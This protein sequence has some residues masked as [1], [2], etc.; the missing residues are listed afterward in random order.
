MLT[1][2]CPH[3]AKVFRIRPEQLSLR[4]GRVRCGNC[5]QAFSALAHLGEM[6][7]E[8]LPGTHAPEP[9]TAVKP[10]DKPVTAPV[11]ESVNAASQPAP[12]QIPS[13]PPVAPVQPVPVPPAA[14][15][16]P[17]RVVSAP[18]PAPAP[19]APQISPEFLQSAPIPLHESSPLAKFGEVAFPALDL[20][21]SG[22]PGIEAPAFVALDGGRVEEP[23]LGD[24]FTMH[25]SM[26]DEDTEVPVT[27][28]K[29]AEPEPYRS[30]IAEE[31][32]V[33]PY[34]P[35]RELDMRQT[36][37]L[38][39]PLDVIELRP[40]D[41]GPDSL[42][43]EQARQ[44]A[45]RHAGVEDRRKRARRAG[46]AGWA[47]GLFLLLLLILL[48]G[49]YL[50]R[51]EIPRA[52]PDWRPALERACALINCNVPYPRNA[53]LVSLEG[54][55]FNPEDGAEGNY[56]LIMT[57]F[58]RASYPQEWPHVELT[59]TDRFDIAISRRVLK[60]GEWLPTAYRHLPAFES[61]TEVTASL[62]LNIGELPAAG[63]RL[64]V[65]Y[66]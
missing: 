32:G 58:N 33:A 35:S 17:E 18:R 13:V 38:E 24:E 41:R 39:E 50:F 31:L 65:F 30:K 66:P 5:Q 42:F 40:L 4:G 45:A 54:H 22:Q 20:P 1:T 10:L 36:V 43:D 49:A 29:P 44:M 59:I 34:E 12:V 27:Q 2:R 23:A 16:V 7:E 61:H 3:C 37:M 14:E 15:A 8:A 64:Y 19:R 62:G 51:M 55:S 53:E 60:P 48:Q 25:I 57:L 52:V 46:R 26:P 11:T 56:R 28:E 63:Y 47:A 21:T 6:D 9:V